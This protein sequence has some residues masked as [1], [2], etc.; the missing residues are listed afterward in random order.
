[1]TTESAPPTSTQAGSAG[2]ILRLRQ[3]LAAREEVISQLNRRLI[4]W[5]DPAYEEE[6]E[7]DQDA[8]AEALVNGRAL[9]AE[10][11]EIRQVVAQQQAEIDAL[12]HQL[13]VYDRLGVSSAVGGTQKVWGLLRRVGGRP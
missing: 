9:E 13:A 7:P 4:E 3:Q 5:P 1:M 12:R 10:L 2:E 8:L 11:H 6:P